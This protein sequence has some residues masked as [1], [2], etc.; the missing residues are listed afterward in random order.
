MNVDTK[1]SFLRT[2]SSVLGQRPVGR[3]GFP[4]WEC[5]WHVLAAAGVG[6]AWLFRAFDVF[7]DFRGVFLNFR[8]AF[9]NF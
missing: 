4:V 2:Y 3:C 9:L 1:V 6:K 8:G 7:R 5:A